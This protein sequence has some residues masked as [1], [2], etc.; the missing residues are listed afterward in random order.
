MHLKDKLYIN[1]SSAQ[2]HL[3]QMRQTT[4]K[5]LFELTQLKMLCVFQV[6][7]GSEKHTLIYRSLYLCILLGQVF[8]CQAL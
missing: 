8:T 2:I 5:C 7:S 1:T 3:S 6:H 4:L